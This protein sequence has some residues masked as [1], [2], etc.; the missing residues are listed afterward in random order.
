MPGELARNLAGILNT[1]EIA[2]VFGSITTAASYRGVNDAA[3]EGIITSYDSVMK[4]L[5]IAATCIAI[6]PIALAIILPDIYLGDGQNAVEKEDLGGR[7]IT[8]R[9]ALEEKA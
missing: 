2:S 4:T 9:P 3:Y 7:P 5:L 1:T 6:V 8:A